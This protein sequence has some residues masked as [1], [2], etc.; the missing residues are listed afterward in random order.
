MYLGGGN[1][2]DLFNGSASF[3]ESDCFTAAALDSFAAS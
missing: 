2:S 3:C 1:S